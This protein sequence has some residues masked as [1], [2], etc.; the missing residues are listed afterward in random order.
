MDAG[1]RGEDGKPVR[2]SG[3]YVTVW[4]RSA[5]GAWRVLLDAPLQPAAKPGEGLARTLVLSAASAAGDLEAALGTWTR[6]GDEGAYLVVRR[7]SGD[8][9][10]VPVDSALALQRPAPQRRAD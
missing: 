6:G 7:R 4:R 9:W 2:G 5:K 10:T 8:A 1:I 3:E